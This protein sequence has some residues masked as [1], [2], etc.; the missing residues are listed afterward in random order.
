MGK[1]FVGAA[2]LFENSPGK[3]R[4]APPGFEPGSNGPK[5]LMIGRY[6]T[7]LREWMLG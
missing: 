4:I 7:G 5:P 3:R 6:T 1:E 2:G